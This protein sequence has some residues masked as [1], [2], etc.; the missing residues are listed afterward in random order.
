MCIVLH[1]RVLPL[2]C[3]VLL[4]VHLLVYPFVYLL[5][6]CTQMQCLSGSLQSLY[7]ELA[8]ND[9]PILFQANLLSCLSTAMGLVHKPPLPNGVVNL[10]Q[11]ETYSV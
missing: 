10:Q 11:Y 2:S 6:A 3:G 9:Q 8:I 5:L 4:L 7:G 1:C